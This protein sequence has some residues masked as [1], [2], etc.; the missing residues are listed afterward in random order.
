MLLSM[1]QAMRDC[2]DVH[3]IA[4]ADGPLL[5]QAEHTGASSHLLQI[6]GR[7]AAL[8]DSA[9]S[10]PHR[11]GSLALVWLRMAWE[12]L[13]ALPAGVHFAHELAKKIEAL[14]PDLV[15]SNGN[16]THLLLKLAKFDKAPIV[17]HLHDFIGQ[18]RL[19]SRLLRCETMPAAAIAVSRSVAEDAATFLRR[20]K[21]QVVYNTVNL[22]RFTPRVSQG[23][24]LDKLAGLP[25]AEP[26]TVRVGLVGT[27]ARWKGQDIFLQSAGLLAARADTRPLRFYIIGGPIYSTAGSQFTREEL[28]AVASQHG[29]AENV[30]FIPFQENVADVYRDLDIVVHASTK[31]EPFGLTIAEAMACGRAVIVSCAGGAKELFTDEYDAVAVPPGDFKSLAAAIRRLANENSLRAVLGANARRTACER[32][33][34]HGLS[35]A[36][37]QVYAPLVPHGQT[38]E[39]A[40]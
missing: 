33:S 7:L 9:V 13:L 21:L 30:G 19:M 4:L 32:F 2:A 11:A 27:F 1:I 23:L 26:G 17:W 40:P 22:D 5:E 34:S 37:S 6:P 31:P 18:R 35:S 16:K 14:R 38:A 29:L 10:S 28:Q 20:D 3:L 39:I 36:L 8:G 15:H 24:E 12:G 25:P